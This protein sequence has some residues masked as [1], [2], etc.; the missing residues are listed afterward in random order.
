MEKTIYYSIKEME[1]VRKRNY[2]IAKNFA[3]VVRMLLRDKNIN[4]MLLSYE[5]ATHKGKE[6]ERY[7]LDC[8][9]KNYKIKDIVQYLKNSRLWQIKRGLGLFV[10]HSLVYY[11]K[12]ILIPEKNLYSTG[13]Q[14]K[15]FYIK[16]A[17]G[18]YKAVDLK[19]S[20]FK[21]AD[22]IYK[23]RDSIYNSE[24]VLYREHIEA[25][26]EAIKEK[27]NKKLINV[28]IYVYNSLRL[29]TDDIYYI[30]QEKNSPS[31]QFGEFDFIDLD[32]YQLSQSY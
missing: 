3:R 16:F 27:D 6:E 2:K 8:Y 1:R 30:I 10:E 5:I 14:G 23:D 22:K 17:D 19:V 13:K 20:F 15:D 31:Y 9:L 29:R 7:L 26:F 25:I 18:K 32:S 21:E 11:F 12:D 24:V 28:L 4:V